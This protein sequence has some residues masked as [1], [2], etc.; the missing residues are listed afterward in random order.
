MTLVFSPKTKYYYLNF[1]W[2]AVRPSQSH[3]PTYN[4]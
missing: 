3:S 1:S 2:M 4:F